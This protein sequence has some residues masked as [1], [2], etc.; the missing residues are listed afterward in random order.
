MHRFEQQ[1]LYTAGEG[2]YARY[3]IPALAA[4]EAGTVLAFCEAR[5][6][7]GRDS[8]QIDLF[9]RERERSQFVIRDNE[10]DD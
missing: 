3:R 5:K 9:L 8:D 10:I 4:T 2:G 1:N 6:F 7:T